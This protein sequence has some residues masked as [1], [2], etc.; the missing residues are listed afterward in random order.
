M[1]MSTA[2]SLRS[3]RALAA[4]LVVLCLYVGSLLPAKAQPGID[5]IPLSNDYV[6]R[7]WD[8]EDGLVANDT[9][10]IAETPNGYLWIATWSGL[11]RFDGVRFTTFSKADGLGM[12]SDNVNSVFCA[13]DG[14]LWI[15]FGREGLAYYRAGQFHIAHVG[16]PSDVGSGTSSL[17]EDADGAIW[18]GIQP[19]PSAIRWKDGKVTRF[20]NA[21]GFGSG[22]NPTLCASLDG[23][24]WFATNADCG[25]FDGRRFRQLWAADGRDVH[26]GAARSGGMWVSRGQQLFHYWA[27]G[28]REIIAD[29]TWLG[30]AKALRVLYEDREGNLWL[31]TLNA[32]LFLFRNGQFSHVPTSQSSITSILED[33]DGNVWV[34]TQGGGLDRLR[35]RCFFLRKAKTDSVVRDETTCSLGVDDQGRMNLSQGHTLVRATDAS[36]RTFAVPPGEVVG[37]VFTLT[38]AQAGGLWL[39]GLE[40]QIRLWKDGKILVGQFMPGAITSLL[41]DR[42]QNLWISSIHGAL[43]CRRNGIISPVEQNGLIEPRALALDGQGKVWAGT[44]AGLVFRR[45]GGN[46][47]PVPLPDGKKGERIE[48]IVPTGKDT[49]WIGALGGGLYRWRAGR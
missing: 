15:G 26:I 3:S 23:T 12:P 19:G 5:A 43:Y 37:D 46:F 11:S 34:G 22:F 2:T 38:P 6:L 27:D 45:E 8:T 44:E 48:F 21:D 17:V 39:G 1:K 32:G 30:G 36:S 9:L 28:K 41:E 35:P 42:D 47:Q 18:G 7:T 25:F 16:P 40:F 31:G 20:S 13:K 29:L 49:L 24:V 4:S 14:T 33:R 10:D